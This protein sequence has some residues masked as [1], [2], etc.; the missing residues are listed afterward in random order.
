M[1]KRKVNGNPR[2]SNNLKI[3]KQVEEKKKFT[4][5]LKVTNE[6][7]TNTKLKIQDIRASQLKDFAAHSSMTFQSNKNMCNKVDYNSIMSHDPKLVSSKDYCAKDKEV[8][9][10]TATSKLNHNNELGKDCPQAQD[11]VTNFIDD[12]FSKEAPLDTIKNSFLNNDVLQVKMYTKVKQ[13]ILSHVNYGNS[14]CNYDDNVTSSKFQGK[15]KYDNVQ[16][17]TFDVKE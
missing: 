2:M 3:L 16:V 12:C 7:S 9:N 14:K 5:I 13:N 8:F 10:P 4:E 6:K 17:D 11:F 1:L 15:L